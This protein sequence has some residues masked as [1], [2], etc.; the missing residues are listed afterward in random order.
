MSKYFFCHCKGFAG[1]GVTACDAGSASR[2]AEPTGCGS[3]R[4]ADFYNL[5]GHFCVKV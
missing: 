4:S 1:D 3:G 5:K 2:P